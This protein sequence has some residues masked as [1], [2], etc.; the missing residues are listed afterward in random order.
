MLCLGNKA[1]F[2]KVK[3]NSQVVP[4]RVYTMPCPS[5]PPCS[6]AALLEPVSPSLSQ[7]AQGGTQKDLPLVT[8][9]PT[10]AP[11]GVLFILACGLAG[12]CVKSSSYE[13]FKPHLSLQERWFP[14]DVGMP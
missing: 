14:L 9:Q 13:T 11:L 8:P 1:V 6:G 10:L 5:P 12:G 2:E 7:F 3:A 4:T